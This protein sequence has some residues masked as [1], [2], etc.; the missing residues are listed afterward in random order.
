MCLNCL[1]FPWKLHCDFIFAFQLKVLKITI[2]CLVLCVFSAQ[3]TDPSNWNVKAPD[4][5]FFCFL[6]CTLH[7]LVSTRMKCR[8][9]V[10]F[11]QVHNLLW[12]CFV[13]LLPQHLVLN[14]NFLFTRK[15]AETYF[16][17]RKLTTTLVII[18]IKVYN[19][20]NYYNVP[21]RFQKVAEKTLYKNKSDYCWI[22][23]NF[24]SSLLYCRQLPVTEYSV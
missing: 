11:C 20:Y 13:Q 3:T 2:L 12:F 18:E 7:K 16:L 5:P 14:A 21:L 6:N 9:F 8:P 17:F 15:L 19:Y 4:N 23:L 22:C 10:R 1:D 24:L